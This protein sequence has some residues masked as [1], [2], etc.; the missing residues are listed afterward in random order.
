MVLLYGPGR[1]QFLMSE[2]A[3]YQSAK[4][5]SLVRSS[6]NETCFRV[7]GFITQSTI[8]Y[9]LTLLVAITVLHRSCPVAA[10]PLHR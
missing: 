9:Q 8:V 6:N 10:E 1:V 7:S 3:L 5:P 4:T 2:V